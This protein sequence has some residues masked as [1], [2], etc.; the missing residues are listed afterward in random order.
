MSLNPLARY[1]GKNLVLLLFAPGPQ[2]V[3]L[4]DQRIL[5]RRYEADLRRRA[6]VSIA[7]V[8][9]RHRAEDR[10]LHARFAVPWGAF[11][12]ILVGRDGGVIFE[13]STPLTA[14]AL[15]FRIDTARPSSR[16]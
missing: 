9:P 1:R 13:G 2:E 4:R 12:L 6:V 8:A 10:M 11:R 14:D 3:R 15:F 5:L 16:R 7:V